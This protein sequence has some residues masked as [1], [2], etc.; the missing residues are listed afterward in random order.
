MTVRGGIFGRMGCGHGT[1]LLAL[2]ASPLLAQ[3]SSALLDLSVV[4]AKKAPLTG[5]VVTLTN[6]ETG[7]SRKAATDASGR[8]RVAALSP[9]TYRFHL[10]LAGYT[11]AT[12]GDLVLLV[13]QTKQVNATMVPVQAAEVAV[14]GAAPVVDTLKT[15]AST[16]VTP[17]QIEGLPVLDRQ[18]ERLAFITPGVQRERGAFRFIGGGPVLGAGGNASQSTIMVDG[19]DSTDQALGLARTRFSQDAIREFKVVT[20]RF[21]TE[22]GGSAGGAINVVTKTGTNDYSGSAYAFFRNDSLRAKG[23]LEKDNLAYKRSQLGATFGGPI[24]KDRT[25]FFVSAE[26]IQEDAI[27]LFRPQGYFAPL[28]KDVTVPMKQTLLFL[29][30]DH[31]L[32]QS[33]QLRGTFVYER[34]RQE[35]F[36]VGGVSDESN[37]QQ[38]NRDNMNATVEHI[39]TGSRF[40]NELRVQYGKRKYE[41]PTNSNRMEEWFSGGVTLKTGGSLY[42]DMLQDGKILEIRDTAH[43][44]FGDHNLKAGFSFAHLMERYRFDTYQHGMLYYLNDPT[45]TTKA[46]PYAYFYGEGSSDVEKGTNLWGLFIQDDWRLLPNLTVNAGLRWD[47]DTA[48]NNPDFRHALVPNGRSRDTNNWQ[49]RLGFSWD[50]NSDG[51]HIARGGV[52]RF[53]GRYLLVPAFIE[54]QQNGETGRRMLTR[55]NGAL[56]GVP[57]LTLDPANPKTTGILSVGKDIAL[58]D[59][60]LEAP[61]ADQATLGYMM[62]IGQTGLYF[63]AEATYVKGRKEI[64]LRDKNFVGN[65]NVHPPASIRINPAYGQINVYTNEGRSEYKA[66]TLSVNGTF[67]DGNMFNAAL[68]LSDK[69]NIADDFSPEFPTGYPSD[70]ARIDADWGHSRSQESMRLVLSGIFRLPWEFTLAPIIEYGSGQPWTRRLGYDFNGDGKTG[71]RAVGDP[72]FGQDGTLFR[73]VSVRLTR[74]FKIGPK[75]KLDLIAEVFNLFNTVNYD[76]NSIDNARYS[77]GPTLANPAAAAVAN[78]NFG[79]YYATMKPREA[80]VGVK[81]SF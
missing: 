25:H 69:K 1:V 49:P 70:P 9:G 36:R 35:N 48:G 45:A 56:F 14:V 20:S 38:L 39:Y 58:L 71:D 31:T 53:T 8:V 41:E 11:G 72:R 68:T 10:E 17:E 51:R 23:A 57:S 13:G 47:L 21:D 80:Q 50:I 78:N 74:T 27:A 67:G 37:G 65:E 75:S 55:L 3:S 19:V 16:N 62:R 5:V 18:F 30:L 61:E 46:T 4:D 24:V 7:Y 34:S 32:S 12:G 42:G 79:K 77:A 44:Y 76:I 40:L 33:Q 66:L 59:K 63:D 28:A 43:F 26:N 64:I 54:L 15:D 6:K 2:V 81:F 73:Q 60:D 29:S 52:G 22:I